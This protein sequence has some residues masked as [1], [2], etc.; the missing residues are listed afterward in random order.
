MSRLFI[1]DG[2]IREFKVTNNKVIATIE[3]GKRTVSNPL[4]EDFL[5]AGWEEYTIPEPSPYIPTYEERVS[6]LIR[7][8][9]SLDNELAI[10]RQRDTKP[11]EFQEYFDFCEN[12]KR[13]AKGE[14]E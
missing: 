1:K 12:C 11:E 6:E 4:L 8:R 5:A 9:Y 14:E 7:E 2:K 10:Q 13:I 3:I